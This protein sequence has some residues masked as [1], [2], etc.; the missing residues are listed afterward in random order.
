MASI[1]RVKQA[2]SSARPAFG[3]WSTIPDA[4]AVELIAGLD[5]DYICVDQQH[6]V[7]GYASMVS[8]VRTIESAGATPIVR[9]PNNEPWML[10]RILDAG[11]L[12]VIVPMVNDAAEAARAV[13]ACRFPPEGARSY[14]PI[15]ASSVVGSKDPEAL[16]NEVLCMVQIETLE[17][18]RNVEEI[19]ATPG[20]DGIYIGP[21]DLALG[22][23]LPLDLGSG[24]AEHAEAIER[25]REACQKN[26][27]AAGLHGTSGESAREYA[28]QGFS[29]VNVAVDYL[30]LPAAVR[31][32]VDKARNRQA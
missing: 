25:V 21:A 9:V 12:G 30:L 8:M 6:G 14:G 20:L 2:W 31:Q 1:N 29:I 26:G 17:G 24:K 27:I 3:F 16:A 19:A 18:L 4:F 32:E 15:R 11:A 28:E 7:I 22:L 13:S 10:M 5:L 23:G